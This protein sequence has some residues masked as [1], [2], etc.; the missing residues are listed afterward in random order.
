MSGDV[1]VGYFF[2]SKLP[3]HVW[4]LAL[5]V[6]KRFLATTGV[7]APNGISIGLDVFAQQRIS[8][9]YNI[10]RPFPPLKIPLLMEDL[11]SHVIYGSLGGPTRVFAGS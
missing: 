11:D 6:N 10:R 7:H 3:V 5:T 1:F 9:L 2:P 8:I 4:G